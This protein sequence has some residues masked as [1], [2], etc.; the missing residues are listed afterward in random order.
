MFNVHAYTSA[1]CMLLVCVSMSVIQ[2]YLKGK[3]LTLFMNQ[4][5]YSHEANFNK[6]LISTEIYTV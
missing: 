5:A 3:F 4:S 1:T 6:Y 2:S